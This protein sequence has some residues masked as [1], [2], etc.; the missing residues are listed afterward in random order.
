[1]KGGN[2]CLS[3]K[4][5][6]NFTMKR[7]LIPFSI[8]LLVG[9]CS[10]STSDQ[11]KKET[12]KEINKVDDLFKDVQLGMTLKEVKKTMGN[13]FK[14]V[15]INK[16]GDD[17]KE[18]SIVTH[19]KNKQTQLN[20]LSL[21]DNKVNRITELTEVKA[22]NASSTINSFLNRWKKKYG[23][24]KI[25]SKN[26]IEEDNGYFEY[27]KWEIDKGKKILEITVEPSKKGVVRI[28]QNLEIPTKNK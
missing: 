16:V 7:Y 11:P 9:G 25:Y 27:Y 14:K 2:D 19:L 13:N 12:I 18:L 21:T 22:N 3:F 28:Q 8:L 1:M 10:I 20:A 6:S 5:D 23:K 4:K 15:T 17:E 26:Y 24:Y